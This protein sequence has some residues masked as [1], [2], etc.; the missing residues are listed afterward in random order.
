MP[1]VVMSGAIR[2][3]IINGMK[4]GDLVRKKSGMKFRGQILAIYN[5]P[6]EERQWC[7]VILNKN[8]ASDHLQHL[9]PLDL[10]ELDV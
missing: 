3:A 5:V 2:Y 10:F 9:Y 4:I 7:V 1:T 6:H 8:E